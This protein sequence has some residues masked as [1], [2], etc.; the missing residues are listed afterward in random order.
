MSKQKTETKIPV[1]ERTHAEGRKIMEKSEE[2]QLWED[3]DGSRSSAVRP[4]TEKKKN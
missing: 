1:Y 2:K 4:S 3:R